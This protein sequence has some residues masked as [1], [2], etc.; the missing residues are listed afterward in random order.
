MGDDERLTISTETVNF[1]LQKYTTIR[2]KDARRERLQQAQRHRQAALKTGLYEN[3]G[4]W[5]FFWKAISHL[6]SLSFSQTAF[7]SASEMH[8]FLQPICQAQT[9]NVAHCLALI[10]V[11]SAARA[12]SNW[13][14]MNLYDVECKLM[15]VRKYSHEYYDVDSKFR[16]RNG[17]CKITSILYL[18]RCNTFLFLIKVSLWTTS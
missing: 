9:Q 14:P 8:F 18:R 4:S 10:Q 6:Y 5:R 15:E 12:P 1:F 7:D 3:T 17:F 16:H 13:T 11:T 2:S